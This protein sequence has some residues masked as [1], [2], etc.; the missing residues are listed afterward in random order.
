MRREVTN[1]RISKY[2]SSELLG[3]LEAHEQHLKNVHEQE[4]Q[5]SGGAGQADV[6]LVRQFA[7]NDHPSVRQMTDE[8]VAGWFKAHR[9]AT[10]CSCTTVG[11]VGNRKT[12]EV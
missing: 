1:R 8:E 12:R 5:E 6:K 3:L 2:S 4:N 7:Q 11:M 10:N 9:V